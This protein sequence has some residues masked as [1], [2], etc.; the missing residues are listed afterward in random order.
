MV[1]KVGFNLQILP[2]NDR[3]MSPDLQV[4]SNNLTILNTFNIVVRSL[5]ENS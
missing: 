3:E 4:Y 1:F 2:Q 5:V